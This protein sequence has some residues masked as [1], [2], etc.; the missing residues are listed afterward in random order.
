MKTPSPHS[1]PLPIGETVGFMA[2][3]LLIV[4]IIIYFAPPPGL[5]NLPPAA[6]DPHEKGTPLLYPAD[7][8]HPHFTDPVH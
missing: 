5:P 6:A 2:L 3:A 8:N 4:G 1:Q 7:Y